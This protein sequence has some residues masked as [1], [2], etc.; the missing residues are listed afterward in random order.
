MNT[1]PKYYIIILV[2]AALVLPLSLANAARDFLFNNSTSN[3]VGGSPVTLSGIGI[4]P[5]GSVTISLQV[6]LSGTDATQAVDYWLSQVAG[7][8]LGAFT[9]TARDFTNSIFPDPSTPNTSLLAGT[10]VRSNSANAAG[11]DG[12]PDNRLQPQDGYDLGSSVNDATNRSNGTFQVATFTLS[13]AANAAPGVYELRTFDYSP[14]GIGDVTPNHQADI[15]INVSAV[16][17]PAT[18]SLL[19]LG[20][21]GAFGLNLL[22]ARRLVS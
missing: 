11:G 20:I 17:E 12:I 15:F 14:F 18:L 13:I 16:P 6:A 5:G 10:D 1:K 21:L 22:R 3:E 7:P 2:L 19:G 8:T 4:V 9:I